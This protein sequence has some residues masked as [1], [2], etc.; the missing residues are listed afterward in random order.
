MLLFFVRKAHL[1]HTSKRFV[2]QTLLTKICI[3]IFYVEKQNN[4]TTQI[5][6]HLSC[7]F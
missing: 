4:E 1:L 3:Q 6:Q 5:Y 7:S 2:I